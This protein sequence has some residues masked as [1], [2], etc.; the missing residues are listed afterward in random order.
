MTEG[1]EYLKG[2][3]AH[4]KNGAT[5]I[6][7]PVIKVSFI[8]LHVALL[9]VCN[10]LKITNVGVNIE[11]EKCTEKSKDG[12]FGVLLGMEFFNLAMNSCN[13]TFRDIKEMLVPNNSSLVHGINISGNL[14][15]A[16]D[17]NW[18]IINEISQFQVIG[19]LPV[20]ELDLTNCGFSTNEKKLLEEK[21]IV[22]K[23]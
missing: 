16:C 19:D 21:L 7:T 20:D 2:G 22:G 13:L 4:D 14:F 15:N 18:D 23:L 9:K 11:F 5:C 17:N 12:Q 6:Y 3:W 8:P 1:L 10:L